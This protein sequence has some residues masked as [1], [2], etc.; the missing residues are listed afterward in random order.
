MKKLDIDIMLKES[1]YKECSSPMLPIPFSSD[2]MKHIISDGV[3]L[4][5]VA[6]NLLQMTDQHPERIDSYTPLLLHCCLNAGE[7]AAVSGDHI[8]SNYYFLLASDFAPDDMEIRQNLARSYQQLGKH[9]EALDNFLFVLHNAGDFS[10]GLFE[11]TICMIECYYAIG[12]KDTA[13]K[14]AN[15]L[16]KNIN[17]LNPVEK[18]IPR[19][20]I[21]KILMRDQADDE[22]KLYFA[23]E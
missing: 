3:S 14:F 18:A 13:Q 20:L 19:M 16:I 23:S 17:K 2:D 9:G 12:E 1:F 6:D 5:I 15:Q 11:A 21:N 4:S 7:E 8:R 22:L 10:N